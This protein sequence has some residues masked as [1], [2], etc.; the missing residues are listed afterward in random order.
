VVSRRAT[1]IAER[2][3]EEERVRTARSERRE[4]AELELALLNL[5]LESAEA[6]ALRVRESHVAKQAP[7]GAGELRIW[8]GNALAFHGSRPGSGVDA[9]GDD[10]GELWDSSLDLVRW[11]WERQIRRWWRT[12]EADLT[13]PSTGTLIHLHGS[14]EAADT[15]WSSFDDMYPD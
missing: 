13:P 10:L 14:R 6:Q 9:Q 15:Y 4:F 1:K 7:A 12:G 8:K 3:L 2:A 5:P 11:S